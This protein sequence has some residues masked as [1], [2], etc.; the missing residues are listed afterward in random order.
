MIGSTRPRKPRE[1]NEKMDEHDKQHDVTQRVARGAALLDAQVPNWRDRIDVD[2]L[3]MRSGEDCVLGQLY[4]S[5]YG[6]HDWSAGLR[7]LGLTVT[8]R[9]DEDFDDIGR[10]PIG[11]AA[12][13]GFAVFDDEFETYGAV[14]DALG[15]AWRVLL[16]GDEPTTTDEEVTS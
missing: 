14:N 4:L 7:A 2:R 15:V 9:P 10:D 6:A 1:E 8:D 3:N 13:Y 5:E 16:R 11:N 12:S